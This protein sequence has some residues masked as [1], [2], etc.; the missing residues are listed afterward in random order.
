MT[1]LSASFSACTRVLRENV[2]F[3]CGAKENTSFG[4]PGSATGNSFATISATG[5]EAGN[6]EG[7]QARLST[8]IF[9]SM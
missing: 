3:L 4:K 6:F 5:L 9:V 2:G 8:E 7:S 1:E